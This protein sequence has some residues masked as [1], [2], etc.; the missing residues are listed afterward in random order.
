MIVFLFWLT[1]FLAFYT[2][3]GYGL[4]LW[5]L[6][7]FSKKSPYSPPFTNPEVLPDLTFVVAAYNEEAFITQKIQNTLALDYPREK[8]HILLIT[9]GS[10]DQ[11]P[12]LV[13]NFPLP[14][15]AHLQLYHRAERAG[16]NA[17]IDRVMPLIDTPIVVFSDANTFV[18]REALINIV[19][20]YQDPT[21]GGVAGEKRVLMAK[22]G[23]AAAASGEGMYWK[24]ESLLKKLDAA[25]Y[26]CI[27]AAG[28][29]FSIRRHLYKPVP[30]DS[31]TEDF[32]LSM[33]I[34]T[35]GYKM[36]Y[37]P[38]AFA[39][40]TSS[41]NVAEEMKRKIRIAT[42]GFQAF[43]RLLPVLNPFRYGK[44]SFQYFSHRVMRWIVAPLALPLFFVSNLFLLRHDD[45]VYLLF[46]VAQVLFYLVACLGYLLRNRQISVK[47]FFAPYYFCLM[48]YG[49]YRGAIRYF[50]GSQSA[51][52]E[53]SARANTKDYF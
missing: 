29:L 48:N 47:A 4:L 51:V 50:L 33:S 30:P 17:A 44:L 28:E 26:S 45:P 53:K 37:E 12:K 11:T 22:K 9:D 23:E 6:T 21:V 42:G 5:M 36:A 13:Q 49:M 1:L 19:R 34:N 27:G 25:F 43:F 18:N 10:T 14:E 24:Y 52:W 35:Q 15:G 2:Y 41:A 31:I 7:F 20:H 3:I 16:K 40:E 46:F 39:M 38:Q 32:M 8:F